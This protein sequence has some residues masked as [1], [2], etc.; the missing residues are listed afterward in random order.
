VYLGLFYD[1]EPMV[2]A[3]RLA[4]VR[5]RRAGLASPVWNV[6]EWDTR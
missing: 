4:N 3:S 1:V 6:H 2:V 5:P